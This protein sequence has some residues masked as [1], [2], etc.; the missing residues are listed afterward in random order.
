MTRPSKRRGV[1][2]LLVLVSLVLALTAAATLARTA[3]TATLRRH[4]ADRAETAEDLRQDAEALA[5]A[6]LDAKIQDVVLP[7]EALTPRLE[8]LDT[9]IDAASARLRLTAYGLDG[10]VSIPDAESSALLRATLP[11][12]VRPVLARLDRRKTPPGIDSMSPFP[13]TTWDRGERSSLGA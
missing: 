10:M 3:A 2:L 7:P 12:S 4:L 13:T 6:F 9:R 1:A 11:D 5:V 8:V